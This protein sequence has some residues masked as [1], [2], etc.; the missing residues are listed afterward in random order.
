MGLG[1]TGGRKNSACISTV[2]SAIMQTA[3]CLSERWSGVVAEVVS[4]GTEL[5]LG[6]IVDTDAAYLAQRLSA[7]GINVYF[8][9][10][11][12]DNRERAVFTLRQAV[13]RADL[14]LTV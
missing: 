5:L 7:L 9:T 12:G 2:V 6:Q 13:S 3:F 10:T 4:I 1:G 8:R 11:V 14:V